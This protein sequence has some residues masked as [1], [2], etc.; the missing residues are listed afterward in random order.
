M[1]EIQVSFAEP[2]VMV[3]NGIVFVMMALVKGKDNDN[4]EISDVVQ[5]E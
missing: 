2:K 5:W 3:G 1:K 4:L